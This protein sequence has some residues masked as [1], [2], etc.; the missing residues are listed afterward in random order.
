MI[1]AFFIFKWDRKLS[2]VTSRVEDVAGPFEEIGLM[3]QATLENPEAVGALIDRAVGSAVLTWQKSN[4]GAKGG[5]TRLSKGAAKQV[6]GGIEQFVTQTNPMM[7]MI[8][9]QVMDYA[10]DW[11]GDDPDGRRESAVW[12]QLMKMGAGLAQNVDP[13][14]LAGPKKERNPYE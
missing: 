10:K 14:S 7:G 11:I 12:D 2:D 3:L 6:R 4:A 1:T 5:E 13:R 8:L 9:E